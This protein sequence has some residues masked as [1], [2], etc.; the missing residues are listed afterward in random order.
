MPSM[1]GTIKRLVNDKGFGF[2]LGGDGSEYFFTIPPASRPRSMIFEKVRRSRSMWGRG[3]KVRGAR[4]S[5]SPDAFLTCV[6][7][8]GFPYPA[9]CQCYD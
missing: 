5:S 9:G 6:R 8:K 7:R 2:I 3:Q 1:N 4:T